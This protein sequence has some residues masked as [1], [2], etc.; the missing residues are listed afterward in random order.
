MIILKYMGIGI[1]LIGSFVRFTKV[2]IFL[3][4]ASAAALSSMSS[5]SSSHSV[6]LHVLRRFFDFIYILFACQF[7]FLSLCLSMLRTPMWKYSLFQFIAD[8]IL[9]LAYWRCRFIVCVCVS[10]ER[11]HTPPLPLLHCY[12]RGIYFRGSMW[13]VLFWLVP[14]L[15]FPKSS[16]GRDI[17]RVG[18]MMCRFVERFR[19]RFESRRSRRRKGGGMCDCRRL[20]NARK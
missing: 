12:T 17:C 7:L 6:W 14:L 18:Q 9:K 10:A 5:S 13:S 8:C 16:G 2:T 20:H 19:G 3:Y 15:S 11:A 1:A 4:C